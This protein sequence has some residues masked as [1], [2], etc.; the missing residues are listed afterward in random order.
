M[1]IVNITDIGILFLFFLAV[2]PNSTSAKKGRRPTFP[3][4]PYDEV[5]EQRTGRARNF[6]E[7]ELVAL[8]TTAMDFR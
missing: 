4:L 7:E 6:S 8:Y 5:E 1:I 2:P 3:W